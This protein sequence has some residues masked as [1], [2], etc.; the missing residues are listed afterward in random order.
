MAS[1]TAGWERDACG[2]RKNACL[3]LLGSTFN[4]PVDPQ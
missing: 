2:D 4:D 1:G 3:F